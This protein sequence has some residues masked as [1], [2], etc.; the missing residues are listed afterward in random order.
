M[1]LRNGVNGLLI[2]VAAH[3]DAASVALASAMMAQRD[4][5]IRIG[6]SPLDTQFTQVMSIRKVKRAD[7]TDFAL[8]VVS[9]AIGNQKSKIGDLL[10]GVVQW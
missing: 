7:S 8:T 9:V 3:A 2:C 5:L 10:A 1:V 6:G 4:I